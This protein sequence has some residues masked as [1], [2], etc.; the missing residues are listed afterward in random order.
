MHDSIGVRIVPRP[1]PHPRDRV[2]SMVKGCSG[3]AADLRDAIRR[4][5]LS[6]DYQ[7]QFDLCTGRGCGV[8]ALARWILSTGMSI[9][10]SVFIPLAER[11]GLIHQLGAWVLQSAC[12]AA[13]ALCGGMAPRTTLSVNVSALQINE[14]FCAVIE[15]C[16]KQSGFP[17]GQLELE[18]TE[19]ALIGDTEKIIAYLGRWKTLGV[20][21]A[22]D[23]FGTGYSSLSYLARLPVDRLKLDQS[24]IRRMTI[25]ARSAIVMR[26]ILSLAAEL[27]LDVIA[28]G[29]ETE[30]QLQMLTDMGC[31]QA[32][33]Y[34]LGRPMPVSLAQVSMTKPWGDRCAPLAEALRTAVE[35]CHDRS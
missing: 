5:E 6:V 4:N 22:V 15:R 1:A 32:Q 8:E 24:L 29:V 33:G 25:D 20:R 27:G 28:E 16:L 17:G 26:S 23:D 7:P 35:D 11:T 30:L 14:R 13:K 12:E 9:A 34:L 21:I 31:P 3:L 10:P 19:S 2:H 18:I